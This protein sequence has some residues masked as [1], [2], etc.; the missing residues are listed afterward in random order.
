MSEVQ[1]NPKCSE[2]KFYL[3][4]WAGESALCDKNGAITTAKGARSSTGDCGPTGKLFE[5][6]EEEKK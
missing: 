5:K 2:C 6:R 1:V 3:L 4:P